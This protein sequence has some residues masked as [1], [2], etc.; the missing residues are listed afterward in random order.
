MGLGSVIRVEGSGENEK[1]TV[2]FDNAGVKTL[3]L[4]FARFNIVG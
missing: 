3:L 2:E 4:K 1:A